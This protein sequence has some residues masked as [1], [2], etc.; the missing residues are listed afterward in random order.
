[1]RKDIRRRHLAHVRVN[2]LCTEH[3][4][5]FDATSGGQRTRTALGAGVTETER[6]LADQARF[7]QNRRAAAAQAR[8]A[9]GAL[10]DAVKAV[11]RFGKLVNVDQTPMATLQLPRAASD[12]E[13]LAEARG[14]LDRV[15]AHAD[16]FVAAGLPPDLLKSLETT[17]QDLAAAR[18]AVTAANQQFAA[19][20]VSIREAL[21]EADTNVN[22]LESI[23]IHTP[24]AHP[25]VVTKLRIARRVGPHAD[26]TPK[27]T[28][29]TAPAPPSTTPATQPA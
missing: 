24:A 14:I 11:V 2:D 23:A 1:M 7:K 20:A 3:S 18:T 16:A 12:D 17:I 13:M 26:A 9:R 27:P 28:P 10:H 29:A 21:D 8:E 4:A 25:E 22:A 6:L 5:I 19:A 15:S